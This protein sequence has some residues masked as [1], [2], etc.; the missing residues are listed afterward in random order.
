[1]GLRRILER[2]AGLLLEPRAVTIAY[3]F[4]RTD[5]N[6]CAGSVIK[7]LKQFWGEPEVFIQR[8]EVNVYRNVR[9]KGTY[10]FNPRH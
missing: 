1:M 3:E 10:H 5:G 9:D 6:D 7:K 8:R 4:V 2:E